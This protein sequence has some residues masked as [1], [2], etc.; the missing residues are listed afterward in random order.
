MSQG[1]LMLLHYHKGKSKLS[2]AVI[3]GTVGDMGGLALF[4]SV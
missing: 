1:A 2:A 3:V 4:P